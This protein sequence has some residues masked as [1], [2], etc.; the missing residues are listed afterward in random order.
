MTEAAIIVDRQGLAKKLANRPKAF[1]V[2]ELLQN[3]WDENVTEVWVGAQME[4]GRPVCQITVIDN[5][6][7]GFQDLTSVYTMFKDSK[8][9]PDPTKRGRFEMGEK[10]VLALALRAEVCSTKGTIIFEGDTRRRSRHKT[11]QGTIFKGSFRMTREEYADLELA[12]QMLAI[13]RQIKTFFNGKLLQPRI[14]EHSFETTLQTVRT[15]AEGQLQTTQRKS[16]VRLYKVRDG[17][18][19]HIFEMGIPVVETGDAW[20]YDVCVAP[21][22][23]LLTHDLRY[24]EASTVRVGQ[25]LLAFDEHGTKTSPRKFRA[26]T[27]KAVREIQ[28]PAYLLTFND[29]T[30]VECSEDHQWLT[31]KSRTVRWAITRNMVVPS[32]K[33]QGSLVIKPLDV[34]SADESYTAGYLGAAF[35]GEGCLH[36]SPTVNPPGGVRNR[37]TFSQNDNAMLSKVQRLLEREGYKPVSKILPPQSGSRNRTRPHTVLRLSSRREMV[38]FLGSVRPVRLLPKFDPDLLGKMPTGRGDAVRLIK[39]EY[40][41]VRTVLAIETSTHTFIAEGLASHNC[42]RVPVNWERNNVPPSF[43]RTLR[44]EVLNALPDQ[45]TESRATATWV[46]DA[47]DDPRCS[48]EAMRSVVRQRFGEKV[49]INDPSDTEGTKIAVTKGYT[50][51]PG[52]AFSKSA[53]GTIRENRLVLPAGQVTPSPKPYDPNGAP[54]RVIER[55]KWTSDM[56]RIAEF[57]SDLFTKLTSDQC[58]VVIVNEPQAAWSANFGT[59]P[60]VLGSRLCLNYGRL[61]RDW[62]SLPKRHERVLDLLLHEYCHHT[63]LDHLSH[64]MHETATKLAA[65]LANIALDEPEFFK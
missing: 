48:A 16:E 8:K 22:T 62:F 59:T 30:K 20:H 11:E 53:W 55:D 23:R 35:D 31:L 45:I 6:P 57:A 4:P 34:W 61:G 9:A 40:L 3:A 41:G 27:V 28:K 60:S 21:Q 47:I 13:P 15:D 51:I 7:E 54:E 24:V 29:G 63:V 65:K 39:K 49:V 38:R 26:S 2:Y 64:E 14:L 43:L 33:R 25:K 52:G 56:H 58:Y 10:L 46:T 5:S 42:Q 12:V 32:E 1:I 19:G 44:V 17:E 37:L 18:V 36:Q 50:V